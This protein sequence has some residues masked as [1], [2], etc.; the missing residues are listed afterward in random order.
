MA[1]KKMSR[2]LITIMARILVFFDYFYRPIVPIPAPRSA[3]VYYLTVLV[4][5]LY[6]T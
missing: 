3:M 2:R 5:G 4:S 6:V 1:S